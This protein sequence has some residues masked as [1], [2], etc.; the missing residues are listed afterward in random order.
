MP[1]LIKSKILEIKQIL[2]AP[3]L[4]KAG[5][6]YLTTFKHNAILGF[7]NFSNKQ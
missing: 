6:F 2:K 1:L 3:A 4:K 7:C 5:A